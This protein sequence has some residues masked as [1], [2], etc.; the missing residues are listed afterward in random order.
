M[1]PISK[2]I[3]Q[4]VPGKL[5]ETQVVSAV[6]NHVEHHNLGNNHQ[7]AYK[8]DILRSYYC[9]RSPKTGGVHWIES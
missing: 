4:F 8:L 6:T 1:K 2:I 9:L 7:W 5:M 3:A